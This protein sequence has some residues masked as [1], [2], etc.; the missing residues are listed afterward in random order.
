MWRDMLRDVLVW[1]N[2]IERPAFTVRYVAR[3]PSPSQVRDGEIV[4]VQGGEHAKWACFRCPGGCENRFQLSLNPKLRPRWAVTTDW[5]NRPSVEPS[6]LQTTGCRAHFW[7]R[8]GRVQW[9]KDS[10]CIPK[11]NQQRQGKNGNRS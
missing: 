1:V 3:H 2:V 4:V 6:V 9:C 5:L 11:N 7:V 10:L 8:H